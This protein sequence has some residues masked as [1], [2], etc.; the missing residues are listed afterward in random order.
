MSAPS[1]WQLKSHCCEAPSWPLPPLQPSSR[2]LRIWFPSCG[3][4]RPTVSPSASCASWAQAVTFL[5]GCLRPSWLLFPSQSAF[6]ARRTILKHRA[7]R[8]IPRHQTS[9]METKV[10][11]DPPPGH[12]CKHIFHCFFSRLLHWGYGS[13]RMFTLPFS[14]LLFLLVCPLLFLTS[15][16]QLVTA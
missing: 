9:S 15:L 14:M 16:S 3:F 11:C 1:P 6:T 10:V 2:S 5:H 8:T 12:L 13:P 4:S 7:G